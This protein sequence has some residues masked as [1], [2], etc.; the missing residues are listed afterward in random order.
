MAKTLVKQTT[1]AA[2]CVFFGIT[3]ILIICQM[4]INKFD[5]YNPTTTPIIWSVSNIISAAAFC[6]IAFT[7]GRK[8]MMAVGAGI[9]ALMFTFLSVCEILSLMEIEVFEFL[10]LYRSLAFVLIE[11]V[12]AGLLFFGMQSWL[13][14]DITGFSL[15]LPKLGNALCITGFDSAFE[16]V[17]QTGDYSQVDTL[18]NAMNACVVIELLIG[19]AALTLTIIGMCVKRRR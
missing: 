5:L 1:G 6:V 11:M 16:L 14:L 8:V 18:S 10:G 15:W 4:V 13:P 9:L 17:A 19:M 12:G 7:S 3:I 2:L